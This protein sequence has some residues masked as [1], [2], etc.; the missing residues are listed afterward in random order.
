[1]PLTRP[2]RDVL[3][4]KSRVVYSL[5][6]DATVYQAIELMAR[7]SV[8]GLPI[9]EDDEIVGFLS[10]R[11]YARKVIL[12]GK[13]SHETLIREIMSNPV[14]STDPHMPVSECLRLMTEHRIRHL[15]VLQGR[16]VI[17]I[18]SI[19]DLVKWVI[20]AQREEIERLHSFITS[21]YPG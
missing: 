18:V 16:V 5:P 11:D 12:M 15:P 8:G 20:S 1:M 3:E 9:M 17:G 7:K 14:I 21:D 13:T 10:E 4:K 6:P 19:G 2:V